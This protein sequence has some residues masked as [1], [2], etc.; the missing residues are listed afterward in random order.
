MSTTPSTTASDIAR[1]KTDLYDLVVLQSPER[2]ATCH[3]R[4]RDKTEVDAEE[5][6]DGLGT[7]NCVTAV[8]QR[9]GEGELGYDVELKDEHGAQRDY[10]TRTF[11][12]DCGRP[13]GQTPAESTSLET[14]LDRVPA[15]IEALE[16]VGLAPDTD[17][18]YDAVRRLKGSDQYDNRDT[19]I[20]RAA[21]AVSV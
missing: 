11:C 1:D 5:S 17:A 4:I 12:G 15:L 18:V 19:D 3:Q 2:C 21:T 6:H 7:G 8:L 10:H 20:W 13:A 9:A 16:A 14:M